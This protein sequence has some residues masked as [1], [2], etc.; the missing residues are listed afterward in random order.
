MYKYIAVI[1]DKITKG[2]RYTDDIDRLMYKD[3]RT[4]S[5]YRDKGFLYVKKDPIP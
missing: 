4:I 2:K 1:S 3:C 5:L